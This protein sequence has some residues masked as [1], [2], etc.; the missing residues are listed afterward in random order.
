MSLVQDYSSDEDVPVDDVF[1]LSKLPATKKPRVDEAPAPVV[2]EAAPHVLS[3]VRPFS[4]LAPPL[5]DN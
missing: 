3:E 4:T 2:T 1:G 5:V